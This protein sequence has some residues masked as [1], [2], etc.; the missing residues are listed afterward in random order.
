MSVNF[1]K[2]P[3]TNLKFKNL[4][5]TP[6]S[7]WL[8]SFFDNCHYNQT[9]K[10]VCILPLYCNKLILFIILKH[11]KISLQHYKNIVGGLYFVLFVKFV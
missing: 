4:V 1:L 9:L 6:L 7:V 8:S 5:E 3:K 10:I 2:I 11:K